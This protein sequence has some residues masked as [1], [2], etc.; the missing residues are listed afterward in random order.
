MGRLSPAPAGFF[1]SSVP[2]VRNQTSVLGLI[3]YNRVTAAAFRCS[4]AN[5]EL[6]AARRAKK[7]EICMRR[8]IAALILCLLN[9]KPGKPKGACTGRGQPPWTARKGDLRGLFFEQGQ[10]ASTVQHLQY[11]HRS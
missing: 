1:V 11:L 6:A 9:S 2:L 7:S 5:V 3:S 10:P 8:L 4:A